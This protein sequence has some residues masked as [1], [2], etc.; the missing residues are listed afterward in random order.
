[1]RTQ[2]STAWFHH[3]EPSECGL[4]RGQLTPS[5]RSWA[6]RSTGSWCLGGILVASDVA[7]VISV[8]PI[9]LDDLFGGSER[10]CPGV[11]GDEE[12]VDKV[13]KGVLEKEETVGSCKR[14]P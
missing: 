9:Q 7:G 2:F 14:S 10:N 12:G 11:V 3:A 6:V 13:A 4:G 5:M 8:D 1:M